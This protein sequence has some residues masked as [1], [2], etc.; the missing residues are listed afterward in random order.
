MPLASQYANEEF[1]WRRMRVFRAEN[2]RRSS[3]EATSDHGLTGHNAVQELWKPLWEEKAR[4]VCSR[5]ALTFSRKSSIEIIARRTGLIHFGHEDRDRIKA[6][7]EADFLQLFTDHGGRRRGKALH[8]RFHKNRTPSASI[9]KNRYH[10]F[11]CNFSLDAIAF[12]ERAQ[13]TDFK[14]ALGSTFVSMSS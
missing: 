6:V 14:G 10:C 2:D 13:R 9:F 7:A 8:C 11:A 1:P 5:R 12:V 3:L 4:T